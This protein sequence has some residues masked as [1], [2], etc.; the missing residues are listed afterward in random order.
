VVF[1]YSFVSL[2]QM[3]IIL[4]FSSAKHILMKNLNK[5]N[6]SIVRKIILNDLQDLIK[7]SFEKVEHK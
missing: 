1:S 2:I 4:F 5:I 3:F 7:K 6:Q